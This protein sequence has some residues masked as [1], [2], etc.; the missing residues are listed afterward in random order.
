MTKSCP[1]RKLIGEIL[2]ERG[3]I[4]TENLQNALDRQ[5][6]Y[7]GE[8]VGEVLISLGY[9][10]EIDIV[11]A[12]VLQCNLPYIAISNHIVDEGVIRIIPADMAYGERII[13]LDRIGNVLSVVTEKPVNDALREKV[14][15][16]TGCKIATFIST[17]SEID[18]ALARFYPY[19]HKEGV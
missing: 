12:L 1:E 6:R 3:F 5:R 7:P 16:T 11:T 18:M 2:V 15:G 9:V 19:A 17:R 4:T 8:Y 14:E 10:T 13:P